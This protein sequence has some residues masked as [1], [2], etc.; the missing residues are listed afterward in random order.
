MFARVATYKGDADE[1]VKG[2][3]AAR[4]PLE[5]IDGFSHAY[6]CVDREHGRAL[7]I[8][9]WETEQALEASAEQ[10]H[11]LRT[12]ATE[13]SGATTDSVTQFEVALTVGKTASTV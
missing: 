9:L 2:F 8:T 3:D 1:L 13:P 4:A 12:Q 6:F 10:A 5:Q 7:T 11:K